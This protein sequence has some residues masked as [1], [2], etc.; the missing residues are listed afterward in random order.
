MTPTSNP[1]WTSQAL[2]AMS[3]DFAERNNSLL[4]RWVYSPLPL[5]VF[6]E[7]MGETVRAYQ[8]SVD[9]ATTAPVTQPKLRPIMFVRPET[10][11]TITLRPVGRARLS[12]LPKGRTFGF[13]MT[14][15][16]TGYEEELDKTWGTG[17]NPT[18]K[19]FDRTVELS[20]KVGG[21][22]RAAGYKSFELGRAYVDGHCIELP[23]PVFASSGDALRFY[24]IAK[25]IFRKHKITPQNPLT[26]C[27]GNH[28]HFSMRSEG[29]T[30]RVVRDLVSRYFL[31]WVFTQPDDTDS[32]DNII[33][34]K[35]MLRMQK[36]EDLGFLPCREI[37]DAKAYS[38]LTGAT[39]AYYL[40]HPK[41]SLVSV[42]ERGVD[43]AQV[44]EFR[45]VEAPRNECEFADQFNFFNAY[46]R[47]AER[48]EPK[49]F[50]F[51][52]RAEFNRI[53]P[54]QAVK[55][56]RKLCRKIGIDPRRYDKYIRRNLL[57]RWEL[58]RKRV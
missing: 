28:L 24:R 15:I 54:K 18:V 6:P 43:S 27:G 45:G 26:V 57:P 10:K 22:L 48:R 32:C 30:S 46:V 7:S 51:M 1:E 44:V 13:E 40:F 4:G 34:N 25:S 56:F 53:T 35:A 50:R 38:Y 21:E 36:F 23:S 47:W 8:A 3:R 42:S 20:R 16:I 58:R 2:E 29:H 19:T 17:M 55:E 39:K 41:E 31:P 14:G 37:Y 52:S 5:R 9:L 33:A 12:R 11:P 49:K